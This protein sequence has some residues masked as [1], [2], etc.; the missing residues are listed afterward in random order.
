MGKKLN[1]FICILLPLILLLLSFNI[2]LHFTS[3]HSFLINKY[4]TNEIHHDIDKN[5]TRYITGFD[6]TLDTPFNDN[7]KSHMS[8]VKV[9]IIIQE[10]ILL[11]G[12]I[13]IINFSY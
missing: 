13:L 1:V 3:Y 6:N 7:E 10:I 8:D 5:V 9:I 2:L 4:S 11:I 12:I